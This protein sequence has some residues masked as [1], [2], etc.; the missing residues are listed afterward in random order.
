MII[1]YKLLGIVG[2]CATACVH[3]AVNVQSIT[4]PL[5]H[6]HLFPTQVME[7]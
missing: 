6:S 4:T 1:S 7:Q 2:V 5:G 3:S